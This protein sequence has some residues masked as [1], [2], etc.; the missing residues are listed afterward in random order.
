MFDNPIFFLI[1][2][3]VISAI[4]DWLGKRRKAKKLA[5]ELEGSEEFE[6]MPEVEL[7]VE[8]EERQQTL[9]EEK[10]DWEE[11]LRRLLEGDESSVQTS[12]QQA[13]PVYDEP[14]WSSNEGAEA[15]SG[16]YSFGQRPISEDRSSNDVGVDLAQQALKTRKSKSIGEEMSR[17][18]PAL[19][20][21]RLGG[22]NRSVETTNFHSK[23]SIRKAIVAAVVLGAPKGSGEEADLLKI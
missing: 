6:S 4:S 21:I 2:I 10:Q 16:G 18:A 13:A 7:A 11:R 12:P 22:G 15:H 17:P 14:A 3:S 8:P 9:R 1:L 5:E 19:K 23:S 20:V